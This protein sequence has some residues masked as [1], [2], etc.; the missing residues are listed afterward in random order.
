M[1]KQTVT[2]RLTFLAEKFDIFDCFEQDS[3]SKKNDELSNNGYN[4]N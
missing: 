2:D 1:K 4:S 3:I